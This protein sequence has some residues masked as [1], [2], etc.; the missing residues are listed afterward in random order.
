MFAIVIPDVRHF[1]KTNRKV[2]ATMD[3]FSV[4]RYLERKPGKL[5][6]ILNALT[7]TNSIDTS[8]LPR[9]E[10]KLLSDLIAFT[11]GR[12]EG[13]QAQIFQDIFV[14]FMIPDSR[15]K[16][17]LE[18]GALDGVLLSN[19]YYLETQRNWTGGLCEPN[20]VFHNTLGQKRP[21]SVPIYEC[22]WKTSGETMQFFS[23]DAFELSSLEDFV[24]ADRSSAPKTFQSRTQGGNL[25]TVHTI[26]LNDVIEKYLGGKTPDYISADTEGS[27]Y[28][29]FSTFDFD[30]YRPKVLTIEHNRT[31]SEA[32]IDQIMQ[33]NGYVRV[34]R[35]LTAF[36]G[37]YVDRDLL[38]HSRGS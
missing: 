30:R 12:T 28:A 15:G 10:A 38:P 11:E 22:I 16:T 1:I 27:E 31:P 26:S 23:S 37:W 9:W 17:F 34:F 5:H 35:T 19:T 36:D 7:Q 8:R 14:D 20:P 25:C 4:S 2:A 18:F 6:E 32:M 24:D 33:S 3:F 29:I 21:N 13:L